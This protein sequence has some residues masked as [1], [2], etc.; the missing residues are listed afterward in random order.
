MSEP[1]FSRRGGSALD[2]VLRP[3]QQGPLPP[4]ARV[5]R[6]ASARAAGRGCQGAGAVPG[7]GGRA[8]PGVHQGRGA[9][10]PRAAPGR[11]R[12]DHQGPARHGAGRGRRAAGACAATCCATRT[13]ARRTRCPSPR[14]SRSP[15]RSDLL[16]TLREGRVGEARAFTLRKQALV[17]DDERRCDALGALLASRVMVKP[18]QVGVVQRVLSRAPAALRARRRGGP[19]QDDRSGHG[20]Q[21]PAPG[22]AR[23]AGCWWWPPATSPCSG[24]WSCSTSSTSS[25]R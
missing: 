20:V 18:H 11:C 21:R 13:R 23:A 8:D 15:P 2:H 3:R 16:S 24:S 5:G 25:S 4:P 6:G 17:L 19:G 22:G 1:P 7:P 9:G 12:A 14:C 10:G